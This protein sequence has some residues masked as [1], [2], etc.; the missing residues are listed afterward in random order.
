MEQILEQLQ[1]EIIHELDGDSQEMES[2]G[3]PRHQLKIVIENALREVR[4][5]RNYNPFELT[6]R[7]LLALNRCNRL[8]T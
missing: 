3:T 8:G 6:N 5:N 2:L 7:V 1:K 4:A